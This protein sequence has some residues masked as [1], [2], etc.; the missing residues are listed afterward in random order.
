MQVC[1]KLA[2]ASGSVYA[3]RGGF[4][5]HA[6]E[7]LPHGRR[8]WGGREK[9]GGWPCP[10]QVAV[11]DGVSLF[12]SQASSSERQPRHL[13]HL[14]HPPVSAPCRAWRVTLQPAAPL[15]GTPHGALPPLRPQQPHAL[16]HLS[17]QGPQPC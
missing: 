3:K 11:S 7:I 4:S 6:L 1:R 10:P 13:R 9:C 8:W 16:R 14:P 12:P 5:H 2:L 15:R 17:C